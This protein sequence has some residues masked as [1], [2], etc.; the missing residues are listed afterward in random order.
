M[1]YPA[2]YG[3]SNIAREFLF[4]GDWAASRLRLTTDGP[5]LRNENREGNRNVIWR[6]YQRMNVSKSSQVKMIRFDISFLLVNAIFVNTYNFLYE[7][8]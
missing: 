3:S 4:T 6:M 5:H 1:V 2:V 7:K 8:I